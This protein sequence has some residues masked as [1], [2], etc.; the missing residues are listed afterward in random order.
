MAKIF[1]VVLV[2]A[3]GAIVVFQFIDPTVQSKVDP[4]GNTLVIGGDQDEGITATIN[5]EV[6]RPGTYFMERNLTLNELIIVAGGVTSNADSLAYD[7]TYLVEDGMTFYIAPKYDTGDLCSMEPIVKVNINLASADVLAT[8]S[9][10]GSTAARAIV[11]YRDANGEFKRIE[12][13]MKVSGIKN[14]TFEK[15]KNYITIKD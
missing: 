11:S 5:G 13:V 2:V 1:I 10:I 12:D 14:A 6:S 9:G 7:T 8:V 4:S 3:I 15:I